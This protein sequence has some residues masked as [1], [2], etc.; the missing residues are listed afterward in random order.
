MRNHIMLLGI[1]SIIRKNRQAILVSFLD[2][3]DRHNK[4]TKNI[5]PT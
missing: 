4:N 3:P 2:D 5:V 1:L